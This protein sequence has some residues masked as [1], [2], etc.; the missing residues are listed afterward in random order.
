MQIKTIIEDI[1]ILA[2]NEMSEDGIHKDDMPNRE[3]EYIHD[4]IKQLVRHFDIE[5]EELNK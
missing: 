1:Q 5:T 3:H 2:C 4:I